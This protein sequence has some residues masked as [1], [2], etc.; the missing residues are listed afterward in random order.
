MNILFINGSPKKKGG[1]SAFFG[2]ILRFMLFRQ[3]A[4][5][6]AIGTSRNYE[7]IFK[8]LQET[9]AV[10]LSVPL[11][12]DGIPSHIIHF[13]RQMEQYCLENK[14]KFMLYVIS[15]SG[16]VGGYQNQAH[17]EQ[18][19]CWCQRAGISWGSG[20]GIEGGVMLH[21]IFYVILLLNMI[22]FIISISVN[23]IFGE[24]AI[25]DAS[26]INFIRSMILWLFLSSGML[27]QKFV[28]AYAIKKRKSIKNKHTRPMVPSF[29]FLIF[30][31]IFMI[32]SGLFHGK[33]FFPL[34]KKGKY[35]KI[36]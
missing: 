9:D 5:S 13:L 6:I 24:P 16:F 28:I 18:Y 32:L 33:I 1:A 17:L 2:K 7:N 4:T 10:V 27:F 8:S 25:N 14:C 11:Y 22:L 36:V 21:V 19:K 34:F 30:A 12:N 23:I 20:L 3:K 35:T 15:N 26:L 29:V 31:S